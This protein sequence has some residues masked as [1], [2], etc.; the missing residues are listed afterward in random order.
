MTNFDN[1]SYLVV[2]FPDF[3]KRHF[4]GN[5]VPTLILGSTF[6]TKMDMFYGL[7]P[8]RQNVGMF[9]GLKPYRQ[10]VGVITLVL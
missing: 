4:L 7:K 6:V 3:W 1:L 2:F 8:Y 5:D 10:N 9:N